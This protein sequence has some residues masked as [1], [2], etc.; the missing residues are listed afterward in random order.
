[1][2]RETGRTVHRWIITHRMDEAKRLLVE[3]DLAVNLIARDIGYSNLRQFGQLIGAA[4]L[5]WRKSGDRSTSASA[6]RH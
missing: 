4:P 1:M 5:V 2:R 3:T 6:V